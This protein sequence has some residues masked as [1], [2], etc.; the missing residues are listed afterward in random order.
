LPNTGLTVDAVQGAAA[1]AVAEIA[2]ADVCAV[3]AVV[4]RIARVFG[5][6]RAHASS[7]ACGIDARLRVS[8]RIVIDAVEV[9][10][11]H[12]NR[13]RR[14]SQHTRERGGAGDI[15]R[16][17]GAVLPRGGGIPL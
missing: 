13:A 17:L 7:S 1:A 2:L 9:C 14:T 4:A 8:N 15:Y 11:Q 12:A 10:G 5:R 6:V 16:T 3:G